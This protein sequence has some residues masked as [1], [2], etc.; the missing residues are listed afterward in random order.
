MVKEMEAAHKVT[1]AQIRAHV[2]NAHNA[3]MVRIKRNGEVHAY[4]K[5]PYSIET[6]WYLAG[7]RWDL[8]GEIAYGKR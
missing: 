8:A 1:N 2:T 3:E 6:G 5:M 7:Y 4:G